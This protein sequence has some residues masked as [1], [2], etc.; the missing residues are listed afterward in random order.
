MKNVGSQIIERFSYDGKTVEIFSIG[1]IG[2]QS[3]PSY[4]ANI[5]G[6]PFPGIMPNRNTGHRWYVSVNGLKRVVRKYIREKNHW[7]LSK[8]I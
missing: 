8:K 7:E 1:P 4:I 5:N 2:L 3:G 6:E